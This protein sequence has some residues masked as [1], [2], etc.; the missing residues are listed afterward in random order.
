MDFW[1][2]PIPLGPLG[3]SP[4]VRG[5]D[6]T[7]VPPGYTKLAAGGWSCADGSMEEESEETKLDLKQF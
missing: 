6:P 7:P 1:G 3:A 5:L 2:N 4:T